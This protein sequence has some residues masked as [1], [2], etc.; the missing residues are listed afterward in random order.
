[1]LKKMACAGIACM[2]LLVSPVVAKSYDLGGV[3]IEVPNPP[4]FEALPKQA[5]LEKLAQGTDNTTTYLEY[6]QPRSGE[7]NSK[8]WMLLQTLTGDLNVM[9]TKR[10]FAQ[11]RAALRSHTKEAEK[12]TLEEPIVSDAKFM[13]IDEDTD[14]W[15]MSSQAV[16]LS[17]VPGH[18][19]DPV[20]MIVSTLFVKGKVVTLSTYRIVRR[21]ADVAE[22]QR[23]ARLWA[24]SVLNANR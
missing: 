8:S 2:V 14:E 7:Q 5:L 22:A 21:L 15:I 1:M 3:E 17:N 19:G 20:A 11:L 18:V 13:G 16:R 23:E 12:T 9:T 24:L 10:D 4:G 6:F